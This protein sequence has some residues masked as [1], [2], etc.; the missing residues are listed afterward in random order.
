MFP[1]ESDFNK[2]IQISQDEATRRLSLISGANFC[3]TAPTGSLPKSLQRVNNLA[4]CYVSGM[5]P[6]AQSPIGSG[7]PLEAA[8]T[9]RHD[10]K[11]APLTG[12]LYAYLI[13][14][15]GTGYYM[16]PP[17]TKLGEIPHHFSG[18]VPLKTPE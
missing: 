1:F 16:S 8:F 15:V 2:Y 4:G 3:Y 14:Q 13:L 10:V 11:D 12:N 18:V 7:I 17:C 5:A 9:V 6:G